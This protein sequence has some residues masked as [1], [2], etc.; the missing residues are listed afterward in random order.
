[1]GTV[2]L[3]MQATD[4]RPAFICAE[5]SYTHSPPLWAESSSQ[6]TETLLEQCDQSSN[7]RLGIPISV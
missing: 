4:A 2:V 6:D 3:A 5:G 7:L 1:M